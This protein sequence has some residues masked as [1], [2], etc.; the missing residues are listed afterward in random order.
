VP[1]PQNQ[2]EQDELHAVITGIDEPELER[3]LRELVVDAMAA[4]REKAKLTAKTFA[5]WPDCAALVAGAAA[6]F[7]MCHTRP[8][9]MREYQTPPS[10]KLDAAASNTAR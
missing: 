8:K 3:S 9:S 4:T 7:S 5:G 10:R 1:E 6:P 2:T